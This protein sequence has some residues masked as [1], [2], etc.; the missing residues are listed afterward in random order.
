MKTAPD[1]TIGQELA[2]TLYSPTALLQVY[3]GGTT[4]GSRI[5]TKACDTIADGRQD[6]YGSS[7]GIARWKEPG[8]DLHFKTNPHSNYR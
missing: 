8:W 1:L 6:G 2:F 7:E 5:T 4:P 3:P